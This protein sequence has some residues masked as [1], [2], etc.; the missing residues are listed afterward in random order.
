MQHRLTLILVFLLLGGAAFAQPGG[1]ANGHA[2]VA[3]QDSAGRKATE[4]EEVRVISRNM[5][6]GVIE[7]IDM[8]HVSTV[9]GASNT[10]ENILKVLPGVHSTNELSSQYSVRG[11]SFDENLVYVNGVEIY[12]P[13][14]TRTG[15]Q[16]GLSFINP[17]LVSAVEFSTGG[18]GAEFGDKM[19]SALNVSYKRPTGL[20]G[21]VDLSLLG[22]SASCDFAGFGGKLGGAVGLRYKRST[23]LLGTLDTKGYYD[24]SYADIQTVLTYDLTSKLSLNFLGSLGLNRYNFTPTNRE[25]T[26]GTLE[27]PQK[28][29]MYYEG[30]ESDRTENVL[31]ALTA[32]YSL[33]ESV[34]L[35]FTGS[36]FSMLEMER[37]DILGE[38]WLK[39]TV[40]DR[41]VSDDDSDVG[42]GASRDHARCYTGT[43]VY[44]AEHRGMW[45]HR[46]GNLKWGLKV[47]QRHVNDDVNQWQRVDSAGYVVPRPTNSMLNM[48]SSHFLD[49]SVAAWEYS[50]FLQETYNVELADG[51]LLR[52]V[53]GLRFNYSN[54]SRELLVSPRL[55]AMLFFNGER[56]LQLYAAAGAYHQPAFYKEMKNP[57][58]LFNPSVRAQ[59]AWHF[60]L[61]ASMLFTTYDIPCKFTSE[62]YY[63]MLRKLIPYKQDNVALLY[64]WEHRAKGYVVGLDAKL[65]AELVKGVESWVSLSLMKSSQ[66]IDN[67]SYQKDGQ[68]VSPGYFPMANDQRFNISIMLQDEIPNHR[69]WRA[70]LVL[71]YGTSLPAFAPVEDRYDLVFRMPSYRRVDVG[72]T[73]VLFDDVVQGPLKAKLKNAL[74]SCTISLEALNI[75]N[76][77]NTSSYLWVKTVPYGGLNSSM[78]AVPNYLTPFRLNAKLAITF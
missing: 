35:S 39:G 63:K 9:S 13:M 27:A 51:K 20:G 62:L 1:G 68:T 76:I 28:F 59:R 41:V 19:S 65:T 73:Y 18:F 31:A 58:M 52:F 10:F 3:N 17:A 78:V 21:S 34:T 38:Y 72:A 16:E 70:Y 23:Y 30:Q 64:D 12:R 33:S 48:T 4:L 24:P 49:T 57:D 61:G 50:G 25:T 36:V 77:L 44:V 75:L 71:N 32:N 55:Q 37:Y 7:R 43:Q 2:A 14:L 53:P 69:Q 22:A 66:D 47:Q 56:N 6:R 74:R 29:I 60:T 54:L 5:R 26:F 45:D 11:G 8:R 40:N 46:H 67:D 42:V 15:Q